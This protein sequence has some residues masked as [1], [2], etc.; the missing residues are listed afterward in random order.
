MRLARRQR[1]KGATAIEF[2]LLLP[3]LL[4][5][6]LGTIDWIWYFLDYQAVLSAAQA[7]ARTGSQT[8]VA[9]DPVAAALAAAESNLAASYPSG[10]PMGASYVGALV[11]GDTVRVTIEVPFVPLAGFLVPTP[12]QVA[13]TAQM[14]V[15]D[16]T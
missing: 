16:A 8:L 13:G 7:G 2:V 1:R 3:V 15:E 12:G 5:F 6:S 14:T 9:D 4:L 10:P 11:N